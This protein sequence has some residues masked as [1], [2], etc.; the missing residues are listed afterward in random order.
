MTRRSSTARCR[1]PCQRL[2]VGLDLSTAPPGLPLCSTAGGTVWSDG[3][4]WR[5]AFVACKNAGHQS[6]SEWIIACDWAALAFLHALQVP[7]HPPPHQPSKQARAY[8]QAPRVLVNCR[9]NT[10]THAHAHTNTAHALVHAAL[11]IRHV[12]H[13]SRASPRF[14]LRVCWWCAAGAAWFSTYS[15][16]PSTGPVWLSGIACDGSEPALANCTR[17]TQYELAWR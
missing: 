8:M 4:G 7:C 11:P 2:T 5:E 12:P 9:S 6:R 1:R 15:S 17:G 13:F 16:P 10:Q 3:W 14:K